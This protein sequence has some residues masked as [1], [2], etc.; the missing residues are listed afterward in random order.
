MR[1]KIVL[2]M[3]LVLSACS[4]AVADSGGGVVSLDDSTTPEAAAETETLTNEE[5][6]IAFTECMREDGV[7]MEDPT[8]D[9][10]GNVTPGRPT[11]LGEPGEEGPNPELREA[12]Q[13]AFEECGDLLGGTAFGFNR[14]DQTELQDQLIELAACLR[15]QGI[16]VADPDL[17]QLGPRAD[18]AGAGEGAGPFGID[19]QDPEVE[20]A[21]ETCAEFVPNLGRGAGGG[22]GLGAGGND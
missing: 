19:F 12:T 9:A 18:G 15:D 8:V 20:A 3:A 6:A 13:A 21:L 4:G 2:V 22:R 10:E 17:S 11:N 14:V 16:D 7:E 5:A 1:F